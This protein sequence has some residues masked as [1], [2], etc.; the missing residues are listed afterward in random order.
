MKYF[1]G[2]LQGILSGILEGICKV[3][4]GTIRY[5]NEYGK[6]EDFKSLLFT[7]GE[8]K[9]KMREGTLRG[10]RDDPPR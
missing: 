1:T 9:W 8:F 6:V 10:N 4:R 5:Q 2:H 7:S 3:Y